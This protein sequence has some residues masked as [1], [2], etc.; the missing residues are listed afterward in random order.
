M[1]EAS[2]WLRRSII[3]LGTPHASIRLEA[4]SA[5]F[6]RTSMLQRVRVIV[7]L[8]RVSVQQSCTDH[9]G[10]KREFLVGTVMLR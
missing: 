1:D 8:G 9:I 2:S 4:G 6:R 10:C 7:D 3:S 5:L